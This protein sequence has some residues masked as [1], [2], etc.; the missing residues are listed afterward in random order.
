MTADSS[1]KHTWNTKSTFA[2]AIHHSICKRFV[3]NISDKCRLIVIAPA[4]TGRDKS[5][6]KAVI[7]I[8]HTNNG[9]LWNPKLLDLILVI[10]QIKFMAPKI[11][12][13]PERCKLKILGIDEFSTK[14]N[15]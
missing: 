14:N 2:T 12:A 5:N 15:T 8:A 3:R 10:V 4:K 9:I 13:A 11:E 1:T 6:K 7:K